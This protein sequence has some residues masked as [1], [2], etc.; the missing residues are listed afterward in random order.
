MAALQRRLST[1][2]KRTT[3]DLGILTNGHANDAKKLPKRSSKAKK[4]AAKKAREKAAEQKRLTVVEVATFHEFGLGV[5]Q[6]SFLR[7]FAD[8]RQAEIAGRLRTI[9]QAIAKGLVRVGGSEVKPAVA[10][11]RLGAWL[12]G[13]VKARI[14]AGL[15]PA[16]AESTIRKKT[17]AGKRGQTPLIDTGQLRSSITYRVISNKNV[18]ESLVSKREAGGGKAK[19]RGANPS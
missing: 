16:L 1:L 17:R 2:A 15:E 13:Q 6:R 14:S 11:H 4:V 5:P 8:E 10:L 3:I 18:V 7:A 19:K 9:S 12:A